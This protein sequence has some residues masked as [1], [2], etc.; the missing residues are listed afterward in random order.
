MIR[1]RLTWREIYLVLKERRKKRL[2][3]TGE[4]EEV[5]LKYMFSL[6]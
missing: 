6:S 4:V 3:F 5:E 1:T 2:I